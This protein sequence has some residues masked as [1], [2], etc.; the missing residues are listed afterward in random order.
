MNMKSNLFNNLVNGVPKISRKRKK[1]SLK[2]L[3]SIPTETYNKFKEN[4]VARWY[5]CITSGALKA[6]MENCF[7]IRG[8]DLA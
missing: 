2:E 3:K 5:A 1:N 7:K 6:I 8:N 4:W